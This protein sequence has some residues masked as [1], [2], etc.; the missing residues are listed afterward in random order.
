MAK[1]KI[2]IIQSIV[3]IP[4]TLKGFP[5]NLTKEPKNAAEL[6]LCKREHKSYM[7]LAAIPLILAVV[8]MALKVDDGVTM[9][10]GLVGFAAMI[11]LLYRMNQIKNFVGVQIED[12]TCPQCQ[13]MIGYDENVRYEV[14]SV[15]WSVRAGKL[16][17]K[18]GSEANTAPMNVYAEGEQRAKVEIACKCQKCG[19]QHSLAK[20]FIIGRC[21][22]EQRN[23]APHMAD[24]VKMQLEN[25]VQKVSYAVFAENKS[26]ENAYGVSVYQY[27]LD[28]CIVDYFKV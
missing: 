24:L 10:L 21:R 9:I 7:W 2:S 12:L 13:E 4:M 18:R 11:F 15:N 23:V 27:D 3:D 16:P 20:S 25:E 14:N 6:A 28:E 5:K 1:E 17:T 19:H 8:L 22:K 26:G